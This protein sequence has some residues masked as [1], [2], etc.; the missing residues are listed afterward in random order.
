MVSHYVSRTLTVMSQMTCSGSACENIVALQSM[1]TDG[2]GNYLNSQS[3]WWLV[4]ANDASIHRFSPKSNSS[5]N[6]SF[7][8]ELNTNSNNVDT[9]FTVQWYAAS[10]CSSC[11][12][13]SGHSLTSQTSTAARDCMAG[14]TGNAGG[15]CY[16]CIPK[17]AGGNTRAEGGATS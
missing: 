4:E 15:P 14:Y 2:P 13:N 17:R 8:V 6:M 9:G 16:S 7:Y 11:P 5:I 3:C 12:L 1:M 10:A